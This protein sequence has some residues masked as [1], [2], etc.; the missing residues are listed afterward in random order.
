MNRTLGLRYCD[1][2]FIDLYLRKLRGLDPV[3]I[4]EVVITAVFKYVETVEKGDIYEINPNDVCRALETY[5]L[6]NWSLDA[7]QIVQL[8]TGDNWYLDF[9]DE[10]AAKVK[11][12]LLNESDRVKIDSKIIDALNAAKVYFFDGVKFET[13]PHNA[14]NQNV[15]GVCM[16]TIT[17]KHSIYRLSCHHGFHQLCICRWCARGTQTCPLC[18]AQVDKL[19]PIAFV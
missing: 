13:N 17:N 1:A 15:C 11:T 16:E 8:I 6:R 18:R 10:Q 7:R 5:G 4:P 2:N 9:T 12:L 14:A 19:Q 3:D